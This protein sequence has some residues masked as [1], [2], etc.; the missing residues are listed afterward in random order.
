MP[1]KTKFDKL[2]DFIGRN[3]II[4]LILFFLIIAGSLLRIAGLHFVNDI[5]IMLPDSPDIDRTLKFINESDMS[6]TI[7]FSISC[8]GPSDK[9]LLALTDSFSLKLKKIPAITNVV[10][11]VENFDFSKVK[12]DFAELLPLLLKKK[13]YSL[14]NN[15]EKK[16]YIDDH[17]RQMFIIL[18]T[19]G[20]SFLQNSM[21]TDPFSWSDYLL[22]KLEKLT[23]AMG[24]DVEIYDNHFVD[25]THHYT[26]AIAKTSVPITDADKS[27]VLLDAIDKTVQL[28]PELTINVICGHKHTLSNQKVIKKDIYITSIIISFAFIILMLFVF[29]TFDALSIF[30][31][32]FFAIVLSVFI[33]SFV[34][35]PLSLF[36]IGFAAVIAGISVDYGIHLFTAWQTGGYQRFKNTIK[37]VIIASLSTMGVFVSFLFSSVY[38]YRQLAVFSILSIVICVI[39]SIFFL[40]HFWRGQGNMRN[41][42]NSYNGH[43]ANLES[44]PDCLPM[45]NEK[46]ALI[47]RVFNINLTSKQSR[48]VLIIWGIIFCLSIICMFRSNFTKAND[49]K[50][51]DGSEQSVLNSEKKFYAVW[52]GK[53]RP[54]VIVTTGRSVEE[55]WQNYESIAEQ[56]ENKIDGFNSFAILLHSKKQQEKN[57]RDWKK[58]WT[59][60]RILRVKEKFLRAAD[61]YGFKQGIFKPFFHLLEADNLKPSTVPVP[62]V[63]KLFKQHFVKEKGG[64]SLLS[65]FNDTKGNIKKAEI[66]LRDYPGSYIV[67]RRELSSLIGK[68][69]ILDMKKISLFAFLWIIGLIIIFLRK[70][71][72][73]LLSLL[74]VATSVSFVFFVLY[75][76]SMPV[77]AVVLITLIIILGL[78]LDYGVFISGTDSKKE[79]NSILIGAS[80]SMVTT[81]MGAGALLFASHPVMFSIGVTLVSGVTAAY[82]SAVFCIPAFKKVLK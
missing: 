18:T 19:P 41:I 76:F 39:L 34:F 20:S 49:I 78:S 46:F 8:K 58:F 64:Y 59:K 72:L 24:F 2:F 15:I 25:K 60:N 50:N 11:G 70:P 30:V 62:A 43:E 14:F 1:L 73:I 51:F 28:F 57:L 69:L 53:K 81:I 45:E 13:E 31:L 82:F 26:L 44:D 21:N 22:K 67:S 9:N 65:Y 42:K 40:P 55:A 79:L 16:D 10:T 23:K 80:F 71:G 48:A 29:K 37:P 74:P 6:D 63:L 32:P 3:K 4:F 33:S 27:K 61:S 5:A 17:V 12:K 35:R 66:V 7:A 68:K 54:G 47:R 52:S 56:L 77:T 75:I 38:G 36:M